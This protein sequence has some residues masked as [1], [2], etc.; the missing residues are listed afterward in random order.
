[1]LY[2]ILRGARKS[3]EDFAVCAEGIVYVFVSC[4]L[5]YHS[6]VRG[7]LT[8]LFSLLGQG[9]HQ[10][11]A[12][13]MQGRIGLGLNVHSA[14]GGHRLGAFLLGRRH[15][16]HFFVLVQRLEILFHLRDL[17][18]KMEQNTV[19]HT[20]EAS[21]QRWK[22]RLVLAGGMCEVRRDEAVARRC[23]RQA[24]VSSADRRSAVKTI[25]WAT[26]RRR[27]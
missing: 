10:I 1:M 19:V 21:I 7:F 9:C 15:S 27:W 18:L 4:A 14:G 8:V 16:V 22:R 3:L 25:F 20:L 2:I 23:L 26:W 5:L 17:V 11:H 12:S 6:L 24:R 13:I